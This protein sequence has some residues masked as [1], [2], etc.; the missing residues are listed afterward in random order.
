[1]TEHS[2]IANI[3]GLFGEFNIK[4]IKSQN[5][6]TTT[7]NVL[8][9]S[10]KEGFHIPPG[11]NYFSEC[12]VFDNPDSKNPPIDCYVIAATL[13]DFRNISTEKYEQNIEKQTPDYKIRV[14]LDFEGIFKTA[15]LNDIDILLL[16][17]ADYVKYGH[18]TLDG[19]VW[20]ELLEKYAKYFV[21]II[22]AIQ[23]G[24]F[25]DDFLKRL[26]KNFTQLLG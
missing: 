7:I 19:T 1:M 22:F 6:K 14:A 25:D 23:P 8:Q 17:V 24:Q 12:K 13:A 20:N 2:N 26:F 15:I 9:N 21:R 4:Q 10:Y 11:G 18:D 3:L 16:N 5:N